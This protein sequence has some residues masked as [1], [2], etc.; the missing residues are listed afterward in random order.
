M[1][2]LAIAYNCHPEYPFIFIGNRDEFYKRQT[3]PVTFHDDILSGIDLEKG[4]TWTGISRNGRMAFITNHRD[5]TLHVEEP[6]SRGLLTKNFLEG[7]MAPQIYLETLSIKKAQ[8]N[9]YNIIIGDINGL[10][11]YSNIEDD[12][13][14]LESG[15]HGLSNAFLNT[16][17]PKVKSIKADLSDAILKDQLDE[18]TL[19]GI[20]ENRVEADEQDLPSTGLELSLEK[21]ISSVFIELEA[22]GTR[23]ET[24]ILINRMGDVQFFEKFR[25]DEGKWELSR[26]RFKIIA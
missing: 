6:E 3:E 23:H 13:I 14:R 9:P 4:G 7:T 21:S 15:I 1:C 20:L 5:F 19:F 11:F 2:T 24:V 26:F 17:W 18:Q 10:Y 22:Y 25:T 8:Y 16:P 12:I